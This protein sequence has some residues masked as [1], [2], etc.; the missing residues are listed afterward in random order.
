MA[1]LQTNTL[2]VVVFFAFLPI[3]TR[4]HDLEAIS[5]SNLATDIKIG[6]M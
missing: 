5:L 4:L 1:D 6:A 3:I 2:K